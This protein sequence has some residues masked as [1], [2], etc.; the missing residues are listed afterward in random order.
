MNQW[1]KRSHTRL[2]TVS[3]RKSSAQ[4]TLMYGRKWFGETFLTVENEYSKKFSVTPF[5]Y[6]AILS[7]TDYREKLFVMNL[8]TYIRQYSM[9]KLIHFTKLLSLQFCFLA[10]FRYRTLLRKNRPESVPSIFA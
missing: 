9:Q 2:Q 7:S 3:V 6:Q 1:A 10:Q 4:R 5:H 8:I